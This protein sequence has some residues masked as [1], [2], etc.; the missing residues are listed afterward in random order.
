VKV[1]SEGADYYISDKVGWMFYE[2]IINCHSAV[3]LIV[4]LPAP[5]KLT[6]STN[7]VTGGAGSDQL[8]I[9]PSFPLLFTFHTLV[10]IPGS[11]PCLPGTTRSLSSILKSHR[12]FNLADFGGGV[13]CLLSQLH[14]SS[15]GFRIREMVRRD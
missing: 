10:L 11:S 12:T 14:L 7:D 3:L 4:V 15:V 9:S 1:I 13:S 8:Q 6:C 5:L 2:V